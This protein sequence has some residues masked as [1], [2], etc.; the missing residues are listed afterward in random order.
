MCTF[1]IHIYIYIKVLCWITIT[2]GPPRVC[3]VLTYKYYIIEFYMHGIL[4]LFTTDR[5]HVWPHPTYP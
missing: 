2:C 4:R 3:R 1:Y 5:D